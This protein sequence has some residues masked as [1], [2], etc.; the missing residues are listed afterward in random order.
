MEMANAELKFMGFL[1]GF[2]GLWAG[3]LAVPPAGLAQF[4][5]WIGLGV[6]DVVG[7]PEYGGAA[8]SIS[9]AGS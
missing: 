1:T 8:A 7:G 5:A 2:I 4:A 6:A 3:L 9:A